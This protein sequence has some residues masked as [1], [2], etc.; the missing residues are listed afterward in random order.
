MGMGCGMSGH[1]F[2]PLQRGGEPPTPKDPT[3]IWIFTDGACRHNGDAALAVAG[4]GVYWGPDHPRN[5]SRRVRGP[6][7]TNNTGELEAVL[8]AAQGIAAQEEILRQTSPGTRASRRYVIFTDSAYVMG[9]TTKWW[10]TWLRHGW[11]TAD[12]APVKNL[13][14]VKD[15]V[16]QLRTL[17]DMGVHVD[18]QKVKAHAGIRGNEEADALAKRAVGEGRGQ[19]RG[20]VVVYLPS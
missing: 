8:V 6:V 18:V 12:K 19:G 4:L 9:V 1:G 15:T 20:G 16:G 3:P 13:D 10:P 17:R 5:V 2:K 14:L 11:R 7:Q